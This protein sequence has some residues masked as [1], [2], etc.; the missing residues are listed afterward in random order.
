MPRY[1]ITTH[2]RD[3]VEHHIIKAESLAEAAQALPYT[4]AVVETHMDS[5]SDYAHLLA[6]AWVAPPGCVVGLVDVAGQVAEAVDALPISVKAQRTTYEGLPGVRLEHQESADGERVDPC[7]YVLSRWLQ[8][9]E[10]T[11]LHGYRRLMS[12]SLP[13]EWN[14]YVDSLSFT[15]MPMRARGAYGWMPAMAHA[16]TGGEDALDAALEAHAARHLAWVQANTK[17]T[18]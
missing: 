3:G 18:E 2:T 16:R 4:R 7:P 14:D 1:L 12:R 11:A 15:F 6:M 8:E 17:E 5:L 9:A 10:P 13:A